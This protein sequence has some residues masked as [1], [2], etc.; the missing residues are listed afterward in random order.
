ME[1]P[2]GLEDVLDDNKVC[3][4]RKS[5]YGLKQCPCVWFDRFAKSVMRYR[6]YLVSG[7]PHLVQKDI[8]NKEKCHFDSVC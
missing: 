4:L 1:V 8:T 6:V 7:G 3:K 2:L 5:L